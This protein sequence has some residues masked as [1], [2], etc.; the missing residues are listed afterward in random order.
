MFP[1]AGRRGAEVKHGILV[2]Y[3]RKAYKN[4]AERLRE[5]VRRFFDDMSVRPQEGVIS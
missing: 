2:C 5:K 4:I 3:G 1:L